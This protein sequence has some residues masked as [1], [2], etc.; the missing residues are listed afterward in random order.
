MSLENIEKFLQDQNLPEKVIFRF[1]KTAALLLTGGWSASII[2]KILEEARNSS[3][4][5]SVETVK[6]LESAFQLAYDYKISENDFMTFMAGHG[7]IKM[8]DDAMH[9]EIIRKFSITKE[10]PLEDILSEIQNSNRFRGEF[11]AKFLM[12]EFDEICIHKS[13]FEAVKTTKD[14]SKTAKGMNAMTKYERIAL[15]WKAMELSTDLKIRDIQVLSVLMLYHPGKG[16]MAQIDTGEGKTI[17]I[18]MLAVLFALD[19]HKIDIGELEPA[20]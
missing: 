20:F 9:Q 2:S 15:V 1:I 18:A 3:R 14:V 19:G 7:K 6:T 13:R 4:L 11:Q 5:S 17:I 8:L 12:D 10:K 16:R